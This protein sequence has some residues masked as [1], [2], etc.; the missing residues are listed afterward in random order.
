MVSNV[1]TLTHRFG[2]LVAKHL[3][4][5]AMLREREKL[6]RIKAANIPTISVPRTRAPL[7]C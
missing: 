1:D 6:K 5:A 3:G 4:I 2:P 7:V